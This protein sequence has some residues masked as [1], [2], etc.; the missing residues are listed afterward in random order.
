MKRVIV[1]VKENI[2][3]KLEPQLI[4]QDFSS[5]WLSVGR[6]RSRWIVG[7]IYRE[8]KVWGEK[9]SSTAAKQS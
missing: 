5:V 7:H 8:F 1:Y 9:D 6:G 4:L 2:D 3:C